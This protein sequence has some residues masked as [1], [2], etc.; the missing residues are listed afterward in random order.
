MDVGSGY[1]VASGG[2]GAE[3]RAQMKVESVS[4]GC[5]TEPYTLASLEPP[6][7]LGKM[8]SSELPSERTPSS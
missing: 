1:M 8:P 5:S 2:N 7:K 6:F 4:L 3:H